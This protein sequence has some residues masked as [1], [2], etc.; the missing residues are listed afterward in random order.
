[1]WAT[2]MKQTGFSLLEVVFA[3]LILG[4]G[5]LVFTKA[6]SAN[7]TT[8]IEIAE[9][10]GVALLASDLNNVISARVS[11]LGPSA[12]RQAVISVAGS[13]I[14]SLNNE[15]Q[16]M[17]QNRGYSCNNQTPVTSSSNISAGS[18]NSTLLK[19]WSNTPPVCVEFVLLDQ[20]STGFNG[21]WIETRV[22]WVG[23]KSVDDTAEEIRI[24]ALIAPM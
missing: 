20:I 11:E 14:D 8:S 1:M 3:M 9:R 18:S 16:Q 6:T 24:P 19:A 4:A 15:F 17:A 5:V 7:L 12:N 13:L 2:E 21:V 10:Q 23:M 22:R